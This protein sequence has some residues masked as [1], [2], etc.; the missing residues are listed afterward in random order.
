MSAARAA[1]R[2]AFASALRGLGLW[3]AARWMDPWLAEPGGA[4]VAALATLVAGG[5]VLFA[6]LAQATGAASLGALKT[7][8]RPPDGG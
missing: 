1:A 3:A 6:A 8:L 2:V 5:L 4:R 7:A